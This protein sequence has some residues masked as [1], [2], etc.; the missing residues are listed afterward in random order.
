MQNISIGDEL[1]IS[2]GMKTN[3]KYYLYYGFTLQNNW[4]SMSIDIDNDGVTIN[5]SLEEIITKIK[6]RYNLN[7]DQA[8]EKVFSLLHNGYKN[9]PIKKD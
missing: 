8:K 5:T 1:F 9:I 4:A 7:L 6:K 2:Y 3:I